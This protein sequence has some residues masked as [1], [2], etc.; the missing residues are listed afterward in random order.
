[1]DEFFMGIIHN[2]K[3]I[4]VPDIIDI[5]CVSVLFYFIYK[6]LKDRRSGKL[7]VGIIF[8]IALKLVSDLFDMYVIQFLLQNIFQVGLIAIA[9]IFQPEL[10][11]ALEKV[12]GQPLKGLRSIGDSNTAPTERM[13]ECVSDAVMDLSQ[14]KTGALIVI[15]RLTR[16]G[17]LILTG[18]VIDSSVSELLIKNVFFNKAPLHDG[19]LVIR[20]NRLYAAGCLLPLS[21]DMDIKKELGTRHR[22]A[23]GM[24]ENS[25]ALVVVVSEET[26]IVSLAVEGILYRGYNKSSLNSALRQYLIS[27]NEFGQSKFSFG[28]RGQKKSKSAKNTDNGEKSSEIIAGG[29]A[30]ESK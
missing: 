17:D 7:A 20:D 25:D 8:L 2:I 24:S 5:G 30:N 4:S 1:M 3:M 6:F 15:E 16:L 19:A 13:I 22:A 14:S 27:E 10:R 11:T 26:G 12:G 18:T 9:V 29:D 28:K 23:I 21:S